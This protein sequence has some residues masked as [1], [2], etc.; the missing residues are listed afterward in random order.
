MSQSL[1]LQK[2]TELLRRA[3]L[4]SRDSFNKTMDEVAK[5]DNKFKRQRGGN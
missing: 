4:Q 3:E 2:R 1:Y 5:L